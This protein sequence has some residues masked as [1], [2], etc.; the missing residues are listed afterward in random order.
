[1]NERQLKKTNIAYYTVSKIEDLKEI[2][3]QISKIGVCAIDTETDSLNIDK[4]NLVGISL[5]FDE[6]KAYYI[7]LTHKELVSKKIISRSD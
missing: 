4:A 3:H 1:M 7:P 5:C 2:I 6:N